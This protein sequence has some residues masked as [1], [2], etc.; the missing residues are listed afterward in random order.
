MNPPDSS[1]PGAQAYADYATI[2]QIERELAQRLGNYEFKLGH[3]LRELPAATRFEILDEVR[4]GILDAIDHQI[5]MGLKPHAALTHV[6]GAYQSPKALA[7]QYRGQHGLR[8]DRGA[9][10]DVGFFFACAGVIIAHPNFVGLLQAE[11][12]ASLALWASTALTGAASIVSR[13]PL[14]WAR[15]IVTLTIERATV[16]MQILG[17]IAVGQ[18]VVQASLTY[19]VA[20]HDLIVT[21]KHLSVRTILVALGMIAAERHRRRVASVRKARAFAYDPKAYLREF[22]EHR[23]DRAAQ[24]RLQRSMEYYTQEEL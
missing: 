16:G 12:F 9:A 19:N 1:Q 4:T 3:A 13:L 24:L 2:P 14:R 5:A 22:F 21:M 15:R 18:S 11:G 8:I 23:F 7:R 6:L 20:S 17:G 10:I